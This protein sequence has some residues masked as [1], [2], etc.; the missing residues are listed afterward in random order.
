M[1]ITKDHY[2]QQLESSS[3]IEP[4]VIKLVRGRMIKV[5]YST[6]SELDTW[7]KQM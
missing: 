1:E 7:V 5:T 4:V 6:E 2:I 3:S